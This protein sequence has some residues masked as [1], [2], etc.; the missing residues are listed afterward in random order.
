MKEEFTSF[1]RIR[2]SLAGISPDDGTRGCWII[3]ETGLKEVNRSFKNLRLQPFK[4][5]CVIPLACG[6]IN[7][8]PLVPAESKRQA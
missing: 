4:A 6:I 8:L 5:K 7:R 2:T 3:A 1:A